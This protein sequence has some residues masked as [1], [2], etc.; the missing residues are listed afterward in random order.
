MTP[1]RIEDLVLT[2]LQ[3]G[4]A[5]GVLSIAYMMILL[6]VHFTGVVLT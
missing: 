2:V 1:G 6:A 3:V 5:V 4:A